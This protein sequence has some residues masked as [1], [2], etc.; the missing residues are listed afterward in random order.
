MDITKYLK[1][2]DIKIKSEDFDID[3]LKSDLTT[4]LYDEGTLSSRLSAKEKEL[5]E[6]YTK[7]IA[8]KDN[9]ISTLNKTMSDIT[10]KSKSTLFENKALKKGFSSDSIEDISRLRSAYSD[11]E[12]DDKALDTIS[13][14]YK[15]IYFKETVPPAP[16]D[17]APLGSGGSNP[18]PQEAKSYKDLF[19]FKK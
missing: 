6:K 7:E 2:K 14:K 5:N 13:E 17:G 11:I 10:A 12:D 1:N 18:K 4:G 19:V 9:T 16:N 15:S 8:D 3:A